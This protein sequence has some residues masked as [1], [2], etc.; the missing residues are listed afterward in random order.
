MNDLIS[1][2]VLVYK[3]ERYLEQCL[4]SIM[5]Q[6]YK[7][8]EIIV[9]CKDSGDM[10]SQICDRYA[11]MDPRIIVVEQ[12]D[13]GIDAARKLGMRHANGRYVGYVDGDDWIEPEM[14]EKLLGY[15][16]SYQVDVV[17]SGVIDSWEDTEKRRNF[18]FPEGCYKGE[19]FEKEIEGRL[20]YT[21]DFFQHG[22]SGYMWSKLFLKSSIEKYQL[23]SGML[24]E[25]LDDIMVSMPCV[26]QT[27]SIYIT[28]DYFYHYRIHADNGKRIGRKDENLRLIQ[29]YQ[30]IFKRYE[31]TRLCRKGDM[32]IQSFMLY[33]LLLRAPEIFDRPDEDIFLQPFG[34]IERKSRII[35]YG[36]GMAG[37]FWEHYI[38]SVPE[39]D[40]V[41]WVDKNFETIKGQREIC[42]PEKIKELEF[43]YIVISIMRA[44]AVNEVKDSLRDLGVAPEKILWLEQRYI[45]DPLLLL[46]NVVHN[47]R[48]VFEGLEDYYT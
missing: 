44:S 5:D 9:V 34:G 15:A 1:I 30:D 39:C 11:H 14:Y 8:L 23:M 46:K 41:C 20:L 31:G 35:L 38:Q 45:D 18:Y 26:A 13:S 37:N 3:V 16:R 12:K 17:E 32:Q 36:A 27:K 6:T 19:V 25:Y 40:L 4:Q 29:C 10:C 22:I 28:H 24:N 2:I 21:G 42:D 43:D 33:W 47:D 48:H 7:D